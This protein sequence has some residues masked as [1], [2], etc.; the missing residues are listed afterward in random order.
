ME[1]WN[2]VELC[3]LSQSSDILILFCDSGNLADKLAWLELCWHSML[4]FAFRIECL[5]L[6]NFLFQTD[7]DKGGGTFVFT[8]R[9][10]LPLSRPNH[11]L[12]IINNI[13]ST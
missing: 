5:Y 12:M 10:P 1:L 11:E 2:F 6:A 7:L 8:V 13:F 3:D 9:D 4:T